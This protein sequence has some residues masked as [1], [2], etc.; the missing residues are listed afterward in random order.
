MK[1]T[2]LTPLEIMEFKDLDYVP[3]GVSEFDSYKYILESTTDT[4]NL[5]KCLKANIICSRRVY[6][7]P[8]KIDVND[9]FVYFVC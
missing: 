6:E 4:T 9:M 8:N 5:Y 2:E 1:N 3:A 7:T